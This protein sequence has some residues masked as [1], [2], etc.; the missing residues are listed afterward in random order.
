M[1]QHQEAFGTDCRACH[2]GVDTYGKAYA[3]A[4]YPLVEGHAQV[5]CIACHRGSS[6]RVSLRATSTECVGCHA[7]KDI[8]EGR[9]GTQRGTCHSTSGW[10]RTTIDHGRTRFPLVGKHVSVQ[11]EACHVAQ[12]WTGIGTTCRSCHAAADPHAGKFAGDCGACHTANGWSGATF[13]HATLAA[14]ST[15]VTCHAKPASH[16]GAIANTCASCHGT[17]AWKPA[18]FG[19][20]HRFPINHGRAAGSCSACHPSTWAG[21][22]CA[23]CHS[24]SSMATRHRRLTN[25]TQTTCV[26][27]HPTGRGD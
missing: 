1:T 4:T 22:S 2:D 10:A 15:C 14:S 20:S 17:T 25:F 13:D 19:L 21:Y 11:C 23:Q 3:H 6:T 9:L 7:A 12:R 18:T 24:A 16:A 26:A 8:H 5:A 27:C